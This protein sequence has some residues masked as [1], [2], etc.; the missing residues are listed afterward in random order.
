MFNLIYHFHCHLFSNSSSSMANPSSN[1]IKELKEASGSD[2]LATAFKFLF[3]YQKSEEE[4]SLMRMWEERNQLEKVV[5]K[6]EVTMREAHQ[7]G[8]YNEK[9]VDVISCLGES[10]ERFRNRILLLT[11][12]IDDIGDGI[13]DKNRQVK[14]ME[15]HEDFTSDED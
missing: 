1:N 14:L 15:Y 12:L 9:A 4:G 5:E 13:G 11:T 7:F 6:L 3:S 2:N 10:L 8:P